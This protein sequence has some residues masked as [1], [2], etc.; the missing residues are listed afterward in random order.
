MLE[1]C[2]VALVT[3]AQRDIGPNDEDLCNDTGH[4]GYIQPAKWSTSVLPAQ[5]VVVISLSQPDYRT[6]TG[7]KN[8]DQCQVMLTTPGPWSKMMNFGNNPTRIP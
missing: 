3:L 7:A 1:H 4:V 5:H 2:W 8:H 6:N